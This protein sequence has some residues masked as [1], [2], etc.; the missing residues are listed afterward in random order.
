MAKIILLCNR[1]DQQTAFNEAMSDHA[2]LAEKTFKKRQSNKNQHELLLPATTFID[3]EM[4]RLAQCLFEHQIDL[5]QVEFELVE[6][7]FGSRTTG[8]QFDKRTVFDLTHG[9][10]K[11]LSTIQYKERQATKKL[12]AETTSRAADMEY[13]SPTHP[14]AAKTGT[15]APS[16][17][18]Q[19]ELFKVLAARKEGLEKSAEKSEKSESTDPQSGSDSPK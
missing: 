12:L 18:F 10:N 6:S 8:D 4:N 3:S 13:D 17:A 16:S 5:N 7:R 15:I 11:A 2:L 1:R 9:L 19:A 14:A